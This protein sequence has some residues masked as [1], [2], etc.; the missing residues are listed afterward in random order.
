LEVDAELRHELSRD[1]G[2]VDGVDLTDHFLSVIRPSGG[3]GAGIRLR[4]DSGV[5]TQF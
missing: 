4:V 1:L 2:V 5:K 3:V